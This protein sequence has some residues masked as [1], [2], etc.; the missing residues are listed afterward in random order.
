MLSLFKTIQRLV[1]VGFNIFTQLLLL[2]EPVQ[3]L[4]DFFWIA[5]IPVMRVTKDHLHRLFLIA[6]FMFFFSF[7]QNPLVFVG[8]GRRNFKEAVNW[9][10]LGIN[11]DREDQDI[12]NKFYANL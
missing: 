4:F 7:R 10:D 6:S 8:Q 3:E 12:P 1:S 5:T 2:W 11:A 9:N